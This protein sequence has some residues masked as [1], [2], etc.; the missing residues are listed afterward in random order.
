MN[1]SV[2]PQAEVLRERAIPGRKRFQSPLLLQPL[3]TLDP[4]GTIVDATPVALRLLEHR[5]RRGLGTCFFS[6]V[7]G[8][9]LHQVMRDVADMVYLGKSTASWLLRLRTGKG[10]WR[11]YKVSARHRIEDTEHRIQLIL[12]DVHEW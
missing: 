8:K 7:H 3:I 10:R 6:H 1:E 4:E 5:E 11:W 2:A 12:R 9:N